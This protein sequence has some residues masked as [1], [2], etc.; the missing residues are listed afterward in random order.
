MRMRMRMASWVVKIVESSLTCEDVCYIERAR[1]A[2]TR[3]ANGLCVVVGVEAAHKLAGG[4]RAA[5][6]SDTIPALD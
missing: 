2:G 3:L 4:N 5:R 1:L 6:S